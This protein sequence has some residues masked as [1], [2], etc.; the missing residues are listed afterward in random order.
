MTIVSLPKIEKKVLG[1]SLLLISQHVKIIMFFSET[2]VCAFHIMRAAL[3]TKN[4]IPP[5]TQS[6]TIWAT[7]KHHCF[8]QLCDQNIGGIIFNS[9]TVDFPSRI[10]NTFKL[11]DHEN[12]KYTRYAFQ[13]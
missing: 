11:L 10:K 13:S 3:T 1:E 7:E 8:A 4:K 2:V 6:C 9:F 12:F 5:Q